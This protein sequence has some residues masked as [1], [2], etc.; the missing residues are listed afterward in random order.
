M[1]CLHPILM[2]VISLACSWKD[3]FFPFLKI[4][5]SF[6]TLQAFGK[7][8]CEIERLRSAEM[9]FADMLAP[10]FKNL[11]ESL[12]TPGASELSIFFIISQTFSSEV[13]VR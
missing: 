11:W 12:C 9:G 4:G 13:L 2:E 8:H 3:Q 7:T 6:A 1:I 5:F 10:S